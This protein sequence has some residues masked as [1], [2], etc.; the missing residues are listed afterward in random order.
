LLKLSGTHVRGRWEVGATVELDKEKADSLALRVTT[1]RVTPKVNYNLPGKGRVETS[2]FVLNV[3][4]ADRRTILLQ[5]ADGFPVGTHLGGTI[6]VD[7]SFADNFSFRLTGQGEIREG[8]KDRYFL[9]T[10]LLSR[11]Q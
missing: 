6:L 8:E 4:E 2:V 11:F 3:S 9:R 5:M 10:E 7:F 1:L